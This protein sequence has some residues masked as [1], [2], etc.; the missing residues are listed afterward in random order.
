MSKVILI[1]V[2]SFG[3]LRNDLMRA[4]ESYKAFRDNDVKSVYQIRER[5]ALDFF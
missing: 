4:W 1:D 2:G 3:M 5:V